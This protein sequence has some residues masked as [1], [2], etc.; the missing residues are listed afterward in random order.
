MAGQASAVDDMLF[1]VDDDFVLVFVQLV[2]ANGVGL[3]GRA[4]LYRP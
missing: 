2:D 1:I 3:I 4:L